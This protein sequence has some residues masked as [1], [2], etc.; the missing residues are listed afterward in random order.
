M[1]VAPE[2]WAMG[3][4]QKLLEAMHGQWL[5]QNVQIHNKTVGSRTMLMKEV[6]K[7]K[8]EEQMDQRGEGLLD[9][10][11]WLLEVNLGDMEKSSGEREQYWLVAIRAAWEAALL[12]RQQD[13]TQHGGTKLEGH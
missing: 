4:V 13:R 1:K 3:L 8:I 10:D 11:Q 6:M 12:T 5:Y 7:Q 9:E 2:K